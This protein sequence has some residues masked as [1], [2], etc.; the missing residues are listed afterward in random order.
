MLCA[1]HLALGPPKN[2]PAARSLL[3]PPVREEQCLCL[4]TGIVAAL[5]IGGVQGN[6][7]VGHHRAFLKGLS[8]N[9]EVFSGV[10]V[11]TGIPV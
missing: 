10:R 5:P 6:T 2:A 9:P 4:Q 3:K 7:F 8:H 1:T 11:L